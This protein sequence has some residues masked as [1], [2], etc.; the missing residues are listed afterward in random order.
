MGKTRRKLYGKTRRRRQR[1]GGRLWWTLIGALAAVN[2]ASAENPRLRDLASKWWIDG[3]WTNAKAFADGLTNAIPTLALPEGLFD[4]KDDAL[5]TAP[6]PVTKMS[7]KEKETVEPYLA[8]VDLKGLTY[9]PTYEWNGQQFTY[10]TWSNKGDTV[11]ITTGTGDVLKDV[12]IKARF[13]VVSTP[14]TEDE[15]DLEGGRKRR[16]TLRRRK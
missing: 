7:E 14:P 13:K 8:E 11:E 16:K 4:A 15:E 2:G 3:G 1:G 6:P 10:D 5:W 12:P 9:G